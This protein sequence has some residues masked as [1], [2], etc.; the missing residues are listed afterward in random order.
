MELSNIEQLA[1][2]RLEEVAKIWPK[3]LWLYS[4]NGELLIMKK[5]IEGSRAMDET[6]GYDMDE[7]SGY[8]QEYIVETIGIENDGGDW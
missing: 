4:A 2:K 1:I 8:D 5:H 6:P 7:T 3:S